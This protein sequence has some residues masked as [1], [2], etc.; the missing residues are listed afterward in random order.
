[1]VI[2]NPRDQFD[3]WRLLPFRPQIGPN[4][5]YRFKTIES[6]RTFYSIIIIKTFP[7]IPLVG[8]VRSR[9]PADGFIPEAAVDYGS[10]SQPRSQAFK[11]HGTS[12]G[13]RQ[14]VTKQSTI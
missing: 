14:L 6:L 3:A 11:L 12:T 7:V 2:A 9:N 13:K 10:G 8:K 5:G 4:A 1:M